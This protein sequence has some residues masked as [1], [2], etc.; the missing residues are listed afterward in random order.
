MKNVR[1]V[2][3]NRRKEFGG[4]DLI[5]FITALMI[6]G[7]AAATA[8][9]SLSIGRGALEN[10]YRKK[11]ALGIARNE[12]EYW[13][14]FVYE[15]QDEMGVPFYL[16]DQTL[17]RVEILDYRTDDDDDDI[18]CTVIREPVQL[19]VIQPGVNDIENYQ[20][21]IHV[22]WEEP[23]NDRTGGAM[24]ETV[25]LSTWMVYKR[26]ISGGGGGSGGETPGGGEL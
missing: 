11:K 9:F 15:G 20:I 25:S 18:V 24:T 5:Q 22:T 1:N 8:A 14:A 21:N 26:S 12:I 17:E 7:I 6:L 23:N 2:K 13:T 19:K 3:D 16:R 10:E 4:T